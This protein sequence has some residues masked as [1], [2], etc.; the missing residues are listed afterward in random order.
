MFKDAAAFLLNDMNGRRDM[1]HVEVLAPA[2]SMESF[3]AAV[4]AGADAV[5]MGGSLFGARAYAG[6]F[7]EEQLKEA[8]D[9]AHI[10][11]RKV[12][13]T[14]NTLLKNKELYGQLYEFLEPAY[15]HGLDA[16]IVQDFGVLRFI[17]EQFPRLDI[18]ASTQMTVNGALGAQLLKEMGVSRIVTSRELSLHEIRDIYKRTG[19][20]IE[21]FVHGALCYSY[22]GQC[23]LSS[24]I[25]GR[26][27]NR[28]RCAQPCRLA[29]TVFDGNNKILGKKERHVLS[30]KDICTLELLPDIIEA[31][32]Y[33]LK[34]EGRMKSPHYT[35][36]VV[37]MYRKYVDLYHKA[38]REGYHIDER[39]IRD[40]MD[41]YNRGGFSKGYY[42]MHNAPEMMCMD[43]AN[44][45]GVEALCAVSC[46]TGE[47]TV[48]AANDIF[49]QD[50][51]EITSDFTWTSKT[52]HKKGAQFTIRTPR[53][54]VVKQN[55]L[56]YRIKNYALLD[57]IE[58]NYIKKNCK[59]TVEMEAEFLQGQSA[60]AV[61]RCRGAVY[62]MTGTVVEMAKNSPVTQEQIKKQLSKF[63]NTEFA[64]SSIQVTMDNNVFVSV[65]EL[66]ELRRNL[67]AGITRQLTVRRST[68]NTGACKGFEKTARSSAK[69]Q[70]I[71]LGVTVY[72]SAVLEQVLKEPRIDRVYYE[73][74][75]TDCGEIAAIAKRIHEYGK[76]AYLA[77]PYIFRKQAEDFFEGNYRIIQKAGFDGFLVR[78]LEELYFLEEHGFE[79]KRI[80]DYNLYRFNDYGDDCFTK[81]H[82]TERTVPLELNRRE[83]SEMD[84]TKTEM[85]IYGRLPVMVS[86]QCV[87][88]NTL[89]CR[90]HTDNENSRLY[91]RDRVGKHMPV[92]NFCTWCYNV[93]YNSSVLNL[94]NRAEEIARC[95]VG[96][97]RLDLRF[98]DTN[99]AESIIR[100]A[101]N[102][103]YYHKESEMKGDFTN[104]HF[105][106]GVE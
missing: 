70:N 69:E 14:V 8:L 21:S 88:K 101:V 95:G 76:D 18:H 46:K 60:R 27:G 6:N 52:A 17:K 105:L 65:Q 97:M 84:N 24:V 42:V 58:E 104:G 13:L 82:I 93:I 10:H 39:D 90:L 2:G 22:S 81:Y 34:I 38:G 96:R 35:A 31:G 30:P 44:H 37:S 71:K 12:Y 32:V 83:I 47:L 89:G 67:A 26:S 66:N 74:S 23:L 16:V 50:V 78:N 4:N 59:E 5:Y 85:L 87:M 80:T 11:G 43:R 49:P 102:A 94:L 68:E 64:V 79:G 1:A 63:G 45:R 53:H 40:L 92:V 56:F 48:C 73:T 91:L 20:E 3:R 86:A 41:L 100:N 7:N 15:A 57:N 28:G 55:E 99:E 98:A 29:Y 9:I 77:L 33:S 19:M 54:L 51:V 103:V 62:E 106:R 36:G 25:G 61:I 72:D 75:G